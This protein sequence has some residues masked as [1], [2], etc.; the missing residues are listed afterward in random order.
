MRFGLAHLMLVVLA[1][2]AAAQPPDGAA[3]DGDAPE[4]PADVPAGV[5]A[6]VP[7]EPDMPAPD[8]P[9]APETV[10][11]V[12]VLMVAASADAQDAADGLTEVLIGAVAVRG[13]GPI[14][15]K[16]ELQSLLS[17]AEERTLECVTSPACLGRVSVQLGVR[18]AIVGT[19]SR[20]ASSWTFQLSRIDARAGRV[21]GSAFR[22]I[23]GDLGEVAAAV[24][25]ALPDV[26]APTVHPARVRIAVNVPATLYIDDV[27]VGRYLDEPLGFEVEPGPHELRAEPHSD[28]YRPWSRRVEARAGADLLVEA[29]LDRVVIER[30][31]PPIPDPPSGISSLVWVGTGVGIVGG[32]GALAF[33]VRSQRRIGGEPNRAEAVAFV[34]ERE[35]DAL[36]ANLGFGVLAIGVGITVV[37]LLLSE[38]RGARIAPAASASRHGAMLGIGGEL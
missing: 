28:E 35:R 1:T 30:P 16:E 13:A 24:L 21:L 26:Y 23:E 15:G 2:T 7:A 32:V 11:S 25:D 36:L 12:A 6:E 8:V 34:D 37:G 20:T 33:G 14:V 3:P 17:Q 38:I 5:P 22:E 18:E 19:L 31:I 29:S 27:E 9:T 4:A 10:S